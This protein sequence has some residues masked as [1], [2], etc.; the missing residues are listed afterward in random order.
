MRDKICASCNRKINDDGACV[1][2]RKEMEQ[3]I[4]LIV[5]CVPKFFKS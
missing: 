1:F 5:M 3:I 4:S 2:L